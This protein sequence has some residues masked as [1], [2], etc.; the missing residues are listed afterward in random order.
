MPVVNIQK[1]ILKEG[2]VDGNFDH[3]HETIHH[4]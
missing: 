1:S 4:H 2:I 3:A